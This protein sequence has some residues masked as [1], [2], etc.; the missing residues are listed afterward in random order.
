VFCAFALAQR[1][2]CT[3]AE[4][5]TGEKKPISA[6]EFRLWP[7][8]WSVKAALEEDARKKAERKAKAR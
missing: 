2:G 7:L 5:L 1:L 3:V 6:F 8:Y 4:L